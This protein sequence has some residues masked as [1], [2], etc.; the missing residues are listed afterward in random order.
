MA[1]PPLVNLRLTPAFA[2]SHNEG[3]REETRFWRWNFNDDLLPPPASAWVAV[4]KVVT[5]LE[6]I[7]LPAITRLLWV[8]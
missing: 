8:T 7:K 6:G 1:E 3:G 4:A 5:R 2:E